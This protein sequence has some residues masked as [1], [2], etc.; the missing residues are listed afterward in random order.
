VFFDHVTTE[1]LE[2]CCAEKLCSIVLNL[3]CGVSGGTREWSVG[4]PKG[5]CSRFEWPSAKGVLRQ[6]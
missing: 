1:F 5:R 2:V 4:G 3:V 6:W